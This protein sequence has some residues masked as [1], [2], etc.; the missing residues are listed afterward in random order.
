[1]MTPSGLPADQAKLVEV[2]NSIIRGNASA[3]QDLGVLTRRKAMLETPTAV[4]FVDEL[5]Y[6][7]KRIEETAR[8]IV[9]HERAFRRKMIQLRTLLNDAAPL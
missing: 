5:K 8:K 9:E 1:M 2:L 7:E 4:P 3:V 6:T